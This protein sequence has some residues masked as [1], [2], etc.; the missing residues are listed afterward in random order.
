MKKNKKCTL[1]HDIM[2]AEFSQHLDDNVCA[3]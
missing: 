3:E 1:V 2:A